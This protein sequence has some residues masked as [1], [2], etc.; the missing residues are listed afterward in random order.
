MVH[1]FKFGEGKYEFFMGNFLILIVIVHEKA[2]DKKA[3][4]NFKADIN[5]R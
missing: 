1:F 5:W 2:N 3:V 4:D